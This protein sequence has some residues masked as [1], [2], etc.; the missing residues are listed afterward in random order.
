MS[1]GNDGINKVIDNNSAWAEK[2]KSENPEF[3]TE[4]AKGQTPEFLWIGCADSRVVPNFATGTKPGDVFC[5]RNVGNLVHHTDPNCMSA[6]EYSVLHLKVKHVIVC[7]HSSCGAVNAALT[8]PQKSSGIVNAWINNIRE[9]RNTF[10]AELKKLEGPAKLQF[11]VEANAIRQAFNVCTAPAI[12]S[13]WASGQEVY[14]H[15]L[16]FDLATGKLKRLAGPISSLKQA[17]EAEA[18]QTS[19]MVAKISKDLG[20]VLSFEATM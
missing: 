4:L 18:S 13:A 15:A 14:V 6:L 1:A 5:H 16:I 12:Q 20:D 3:F 8:L 11:L 19:S 7:G 17:A 10:A 9:V 2:V